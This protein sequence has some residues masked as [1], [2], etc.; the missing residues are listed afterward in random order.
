MS[1]VILKSRIHY[2]GSI[3]L[4]VINV[5]KHLKPEQILIYFKQLNSVGCGF[6]RTI[7]IGKTNLL[8]L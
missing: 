6:Y 5:I 4:E 7:S 1:E 2:I 3:L 8:F